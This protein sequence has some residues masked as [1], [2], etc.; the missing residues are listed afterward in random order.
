MNINNQYDIVIVGGG[1]VGA[2]MAAGLAQ[3]NQR[4][5][6]IDASPLDAADDH[7]LIALNHTS[8]CFFKNI[9]IWSDLAPHAAPIQ[10]IHVSHQGHFGVTRMAAHE[11]HLD[12]LGYV[13]PAHYINKALYSR[14]NHID[15]IR[16]A[17]LQALSQDAEGV[18]LTMT[19]PTDEKIIFA[20]SVIGA[21]GT[22][23]TVRDL[24]QIA[25]EKKDYQQSAL[26]TVTTLQREHNHIAYER[27]LTRGAIAMLPLSGQ[28]VATIWT[29][30]NPRIEELLALNDAQFIAECQKHFGYRL[31]RLLSVS[32]RFCYPLQ[33]LRAKQTVQGRV[34]LMGNAAHTVH[35]VAAQG[36]N[37]ALFEVAALIEHVAK[38]HSLH[39]FSIDELPLQFSQQLSHRLLGIFS[40]DFFGLNTV[41]QW[42]MV[43]MDACVFA[44]RQLLER[45][46]GQVG[47]MPALLL[48]KDV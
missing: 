45:A 38:Y 25:V 24:L 18:M 36:L 35:P 23:S 31:G 19:T 20:K 11:C 30:D 29:D 22:Q 41:R 12:A 7:R 1:M 8:H 43:G 39:D 17:R 37:I 21:D 32:Q 44:K 9:G 14:L 2:A 15:L 13:V 27:F 5:A 46:F 10:R 33:R 4:I 48:Q 28:R 34:L 47:Q 26:V 40:A 6:L 3:L 16:P 42:G